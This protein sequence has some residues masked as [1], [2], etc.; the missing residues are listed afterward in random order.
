LDK[1][2]NT[3]VVWRVRRRQILVF[4]TEDVKPLLIAFM[5]MVYQRGTRLLSSPHLACQHTQRPDYQPTQE[6][7]QEMFQDFAEA[8]IETLPNILEAITERLGIDNSKVK[9]D[10]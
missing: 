1:R 4:D 7:L 8:L 3:I 9:P 6:A 5:R 2:S 10:K